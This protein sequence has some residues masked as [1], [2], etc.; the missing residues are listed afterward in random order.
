[1]G[2]AKPG[3]DNLI[4]VAAPDGRSSVYGETL[5]QLRQRHPTAELVNLDEWQAS[6]ARIQDETPREWLPITED[7]YHEMLNVLP[8]AAWHRGAFLVGEAV[9]HHHRTGRPRFSCFRQT[10][11]AYFEMSA[12]IT[13]AQFCEM[14]GRCALSYS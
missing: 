9:D 8:P 10:D 11:G 12:P 3:E 13:H 7:R 14:F 2:F 4:D 1:M 6:R 5:D